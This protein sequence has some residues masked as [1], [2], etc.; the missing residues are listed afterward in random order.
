MGHPRRRIG[1][2]DTEQ[3]AV[4]F[5]HA[6]VLDRNAHTRGEIGGDPGEK[7]DSAPVASA[8]SSNK[9]IGS[10]PYGAG[11]KRAASSPSQG[12]HRLRAGSQ[13]P[14]YRN[15]ESSH[16]PLRAVDQRASRRQVKRDGIAIENHAQSPFAAKVTPD[17]AR[18]GCH[19]DRQP[20]A[21]NR[22]SCHILNRAKTAITVMPR[23]WLHRED[24]GPERK[25]ARTERQTKLPPSLRLNWSDD[26]GIRCRHGAVKPPSRRRGVN[27]SVRHT[28]INHIDFSM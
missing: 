27:L 19:K 23:L 17:I 22:P 5:D 6:E 2:P 28:I 14:R 24:D 3:P 12:C 10:Q 8:R 1:P 20:A 16:A 9:K 21:T 11:H 4:S 26:A 13:P 15:R 7:G 25:K 18:K